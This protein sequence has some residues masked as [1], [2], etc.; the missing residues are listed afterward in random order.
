MYFY[1]NRLYLVILYN[2]QNTLDIIGKESLLTSESEFFLSFILYRV[3]GRCSDDKETAC[4]AGDQGSIPG[5]GISPG[6]GRG[7]PL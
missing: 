5:L 1:S 3:P 7:N 2:R 6:E 4:N